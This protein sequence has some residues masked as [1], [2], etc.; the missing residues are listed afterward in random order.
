MRKKL[1]FYILL[2]IVITWIFCVLPQDKKIYSIKINSENIPL[3]LANTQALREKGLSGMKFLPENKGM[4]FIFPLPGKYGFW[5][6]DMKFSIDIIWIA[7]N[8]KITSIEKN[9][10]PETYPHVFIPPENSLY[11]LETNT[12][13][14]DRYGLMVGNILDITKK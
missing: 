7:A 4:F 9:V 3:I 1:P 13:F 6:K 2:I 5:M 8:R 11:V 14:A 10:F 12:G